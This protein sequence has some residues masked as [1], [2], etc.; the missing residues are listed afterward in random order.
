[1]PED[2]RLIGKPGEIKVTYAKDGSKIE[3][4]IGSDGRAIA[5]RHHLSLIHI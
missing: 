4:K 5:E 1:M 3:T 2:Y